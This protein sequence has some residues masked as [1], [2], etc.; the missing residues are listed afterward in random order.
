MFRKIA[1]LGAGHGG[2]AFSG[3]LA[4]KG[5]EVGLYEHPKF[6]ENIKEIKAIE[7]TPGVGSPP[8][9]YPEYI[10]KYRYIQDKGKRLILLAD[11]KE[12]ENIL[13]EL[14]PQGLYIITKADSEE[15]ARDLLKKVEKWSLNY[16]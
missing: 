7:W 6:K 15:E 2:Y 11:I 4:M 5:F 10:P 3:H 8:T 12:V 16:D 13:T 14:T 1:V 9:F